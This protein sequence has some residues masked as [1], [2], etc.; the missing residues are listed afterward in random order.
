MKKEIVTTVVSVLLAFGAAAQ[1]SL[2][3]L[4]SRIDLI[5]DSVSKT[6]QSL[7]AAWADLQK[8]SLVERISPGVSSLEDTLS[9]FNQTLRV[10]AQSG[11]VVNAYG[12]LGRD[13]DPLFDGITQVTAKSGIVTTEWTGY[14]SYLVPVRFD[15][16]VSSAS[17]W[18][19][20][21]DN[22][23]VGPYNLTV[24]GNKVYF[25][26]DWSGQGNLV[27]TM[28]DGSTRIYNLKAN[29]ALDSSTSPTIGEPLFQEPA[30]NFIAHNAGGNTLIKTSSAS[31]D[32]IVGL[33][34]PKA[35]SDVIPSYGGKGHNWCFVTTMKQG[36]SIKVSVATSEDARPLGYRINGV[37]APASSGSATITL[38]AG[39]SN[40]IPV[41]NEAQFSEPDP[42][43]PLLN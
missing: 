21:A 17:F 12:V 6:R 43:F 1:T 11:N 29:G 18:Y 19:V 22:V 20:G 40:I 5:V 30:A 4:S 13:G 31:L 38:D 26:G 28:A 34:N 39:V 24:G 35:I 27:V 9:F 16:T 7:V 3:Q 8:V 33:N 37:Y 15:Q 32:S 14:L 36:R 23:R 41:W 2:P 25:V 42:Y 10:P